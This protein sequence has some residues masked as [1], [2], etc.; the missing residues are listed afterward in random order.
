MLLP[1]MLKAKPISPPVTA[2]TEALAKSA[3]SP[4]RPN[5]Q[6]KPRPSAF[7]AICNEISLI[8]LC[9]GN[10]SSRQRQHLALLANPRNANLQDDRNGRTGC[11]FYNGQGL[12]D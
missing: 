3:K 4:P 2:T 7:T 5:A 9:R 6:P 10:A 1:V 8:P 11:Y 12:D